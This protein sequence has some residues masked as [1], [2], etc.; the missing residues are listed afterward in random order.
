MNKLMLHKTKNLTSSLAGSCLRWV[1]FAIEQF[2]RLSVKNTDN[3]L[4]L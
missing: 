2:K 4:V 3:G 1:F